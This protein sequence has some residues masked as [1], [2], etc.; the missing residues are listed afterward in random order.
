MWIQCD[1]Q[2]SGVVHGLKC[3]TKIKYRHLLR[4]LKSKGNKYI[5][6]SICQRVLRNN[7]KVYWNEILKIR[8]STTQLPSII[9]DCEDNSYI[10]GLFKTNYSDV[11]NSVSTPVHIVNSLYSKINKLILNSNETRQPHITNCDVRTAI[12]GLKSDKSDGSTD[13]T[14][15]SL[16]N[17]TDL[18]FKCIS[19]VFTI[20]LQHGYAPKHFMMS[21][22]VPIPKGM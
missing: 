21:T 11:Y 19:N 16:I 22:I 17:G 14:S 13:L 6:K 20:M 12:K 18:L 1:K 2:I 9:D 8:K 4:S 3:T 15:N 5:K 10:V 7:N